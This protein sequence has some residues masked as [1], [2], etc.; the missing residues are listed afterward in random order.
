MAGCVL[1]DSWSDRVCLW[2]CEQI[3]HLYWFSA[4]SRCWFQPIRENVTANKFMLPFQYSC[5]RYWRINDC[6]RGFVNL[7]EFL[8]MKSKLFRG[9]VGICT[10]FLIFCVYM[11]WANRKLPRLLG[12]HTREES[13]ERILR[14]AVKVFYRDCGRYPT[15]FS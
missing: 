1:D 8:S 6:L 12:G 2:G 15:S 5:R 10:V 7:L 13:I 9:L 4:V 14:V 3:A 11:F